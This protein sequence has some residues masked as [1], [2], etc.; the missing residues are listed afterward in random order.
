[1]PPSLP[2]RN[3]PVIKG[4]P[5]WFL[6]RATALERGGV[7]ETGIVDGHNHDHADASI[8]ASRE[9]A[10]AP[11][12]NVCGEVIGVST[13]PY[14]KN[15]QLRFVPIEAALRALSMSIADLR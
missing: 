1:V 9:D 14:G 12:M 3:G 6:G 13:G 15:G 8:M 10:G 11:L 4:D 2:V 5:V 7:A